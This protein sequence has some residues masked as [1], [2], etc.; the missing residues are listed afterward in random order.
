[1]QRQV[2]RVG[3]AAFQHVIAGTVLLADFQQIDAGSGRRIRIGDIVGAV[4]KHSFAPQ[5]VGRSGGAAHGVVFVLV[6]LCTSIIQDP[7]HG[8]GLPRG[9]DVVV[10]RTLAGV[11]I[12]DTVFQRPLRAFQNTGG[13]VEIQVEEM[14][15]NG[16]GVIAAI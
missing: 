1:R 8:N 10:G 13:G 5:R 11:L 9:A 12:P 6:E 16:F 15:K 7:A 3:G 2:L 14:V 4:N